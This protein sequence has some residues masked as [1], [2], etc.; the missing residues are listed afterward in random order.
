M[1]NLSEL[2]DTS[3]RR[4]HG[5]LS[6]LKDSIREL[7]LLQPLVVT[8]QGKLI[9]GRRRFQVLKELGAETV[10]ARIVTP[11]NALEE[12]RM[13]WHEN[14]HRKPEDWVEELR[15]ER[16]EAQ[17]YTELFPDAVKHGGKR[18][19]GE[20]QD[21]ESASCSVPSFTKARGEAIGQG[22]RRV[23]ERLQLAE[24]LE[25]HPELA[26]A[27]NPTDARRK[28]NLI[29]RRRE[30]AQMPPLTSLDGPFAVIYGDPPWAWEFSVDDGDKVESHYPTMPLAEICNLPVASIAAPDCVLFLWSPSPK[31]QE[32]LAVMCGWSFEYRTCMVWDKGSIGP[33]YYARQQHELLLIG[34][35]GQPRTPLHENRPT[36]V[37]RA[38]RGR[39]SEKP[40]EFCQIIEAMYPAV[41]RVELFARKRRENWAAWGS[42]VSSGNP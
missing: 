29:E 4:N 31:L 24:D 41:T 25:Q 22:Q 2:S 28:L 3:P 13:A 33:G 9:A 30:I 39:H 37:V 38:K 27:K 21:A 35:R 26:K 17:L 5:D 18:T 40:E 6:G 12:F 10:P 11:A 34:T 42:E 14:K 36:S 7:G 23:Q 16:Y 19:K 20:V 1:V 32:A 8:P 15:S